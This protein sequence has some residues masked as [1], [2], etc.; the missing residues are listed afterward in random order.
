LW[1]NYHLP[2]TVTEA[3][4]L[5]AEL[6]GAGRVLAGGTDLLLDLQQGRHPA[7]DWLVDVSAI[8]EL[9]Q[10]EMRESKLFIG[11]ATPLNRIV[12]SEMVKQQAQ[13]LYE[14]CTL[15]GGPQVRNVATLGGNVGHALPAGD[16]TIALMALDAMVELADQHGRQFIAV[17]NLFLGPGRSI[18]RNDQLLVGFYILT[19]SA[20]QGSAF[21]RVMRP[22]GVAIAILNMAAWVDVDRDSLRDVRLAIGPAGPVPFRAR[23]VEDALRG[24]KLLPEN[25]EIARQALLADALFRNSPHRASTQYRQHLAGVLLSETLHKA[26][27]RACNDNES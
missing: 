14:A 18:L 16:G 3:V 20:G 9:N 10:L 4:Q 23:A 6:P 15:I 2:L 24:K 26:M 8:P 1:K 7:M 5:L 21:E 22:Q 25:I 17:E 11:A 19:G 27:Q 12:A 13:A